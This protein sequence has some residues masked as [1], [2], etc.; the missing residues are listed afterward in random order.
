MMRNSA[1]AFLVAFLLCFSAFPAAAQFEDF[2]TD[3]EKYPN[4][5]Q[6]LPVG[7]APAP[8]PIPSEERT[9]T[10]LSGPV[11]GGGGCPANVTVDVIGRTITALNM[12]QPC[13]WIHDFMRPMVLLLAGFLAVFIV[14]PEE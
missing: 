13:A 4:S 10:N 2:Y 3:C 7:D 12:A 5:V 11:F 1:I 14:F 6:C 9:I 8:E